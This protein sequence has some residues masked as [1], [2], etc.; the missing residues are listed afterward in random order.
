M[1]AMLAVALLA[2]N[3]ESETPLDT[4]DETVDVTFDAAVR[5]SVVGLDGTA[6]E[7]ATVTVEAL[8]VPTE[9]DGIA[10]FID[11][12]LSGQLLV[13]AYKTGFA[14][15]HTFVDASN[16]LANALV[17]LAPATSAPLD[18][19]SAGGN[20]ETDDLTLAFAAGV[21]VDS[22]GNAITDSVDVVVS[23]LDAATELAAAPPLT[24]G[25][26]V[27]AVQSAF[28]ITLWSDGSEVN[29][30][31][32]VPFT[33]D[34]GVDSPVFTATDPKLYTFDETTE[35]WT[36]LG[37]LTLDA[38]AGTVSGNLPHFTWFAVGE[39][40]DAADQSCL[41]GTV[42][43]EDAAVEGATVVAVS[44]GTTASALTDADGAYCVDILAGGDVNLAFFGTSATGDEVY[45]ATATVDGTA[46]TTGATCGGD[47]LDAG[48]IELTTDEREPDEV[49]DTDTDDTDV[50]LV[51]ADS[52]G[53]TEDEDCDDTDDSIYPG[54]PELCDDVDSDCDGIADVEDP[55]VTD[56]ITAYRDFD[57]DGYGDTSPTTVCP[58]DPGYVDNSDDCNDHNAGANPAGTEICNAVD[59]DCDGDIDGDDGASCDDGGLW[60]GIYVGSYTFVLENSSGSVIDECS[61][62]LE[63]SIEDGE[64]PEITRVSD[65]DCEI[66]IPLVGAEDVSVLSFY[67]AVD[68]DGAAGGDAD[69]ILM[70]HSFGGYWWGDITNGVLTAES[71]TIESVS[72][73]GTFY[74]HVTFDLTLDIRDTDGDG[75][76]SDV[77]CDD[78][79][80]LVFPDAVDLCD[81]LDNDCNGT[82]DDWDPDCS[83]QR[84]ALDGDFETDMTVRWTTEDGDNETCTKSVTINVSQGFLNIPAADCEIDINGTPEWAL[85]EEAAAEALETGSGDISVEIGSSLVQGIPYVFGFSADGSE[86]RGHGVST[87]FAG[88]NSVQTVLAVEFEGTNATPTPFPVGDGWFEGEMVL[89]LVDTN[90]TTETCTSFYPMEIY[91]GNGHFDIDDLSWGDCDLEYNGQSFMAITLPAHQDQPAIAGSSA[92]G[93]LSLEHDEF[94]TNATLPLAWDFPTNDQYTIS[95]TSESF[96]IDSTTDATLSV[97]AT[98]DR[99]P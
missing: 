33:I 99:V 61:G 72:Q 36:S 14:P 41:S 48:A 19:P 32:D 37:A 68:I 76:T 85:T 4:D 40:I 39:E 26:A 18:D 88:V 3:G 47:C 49:D 20:I 70:G 15:G 5:V 52:D 8:S 29:V 50:V 57:G 44:G 27:L 45:A 84:T 55:D 16:D 25:D 34:L 59:D 58:G 2:C 21:V 69:I 56:A 95:G 92:I 17:V 81:G 46:A 71:V 7:G 43:A 75:V 38:T 79:D 54:A 62:D 64:S 96:E 83:S 24:V 93:Q 77:D 13:E 12:G 60:D 65:A 80:P 87:W 10:A 9:A 51:D 74:G 35:A 1:Y 28:E 91:V 90:G 31:A 97:S 6:I 66:D 67:G 23:V 63:A 78:N 82:I 89:E 94:N 86:L 30:N 73:L 98:L 22:Q 42:S 53:F 11:H